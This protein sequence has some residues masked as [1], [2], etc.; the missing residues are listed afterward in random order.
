[1]RHPIARRSGFTLIELLVVI[2]VISLLSAITFG[3][4]RA[5]NSSRNKSKSRGDIQAIAMA[6]QSFRKVYGDFPCRSA[7]G[8]DDDRF[9]RDL[10]DQLIGRRVL[11]IVT[12]GTLPTLLNFDDSSLPGDPTKRQ[13]RS[14][15]TF[16]EIS[17]NDDT[18]I[19]DPNDWRGGSTA[20]C[21]EFVDA[22]GNPYDYRYRVL[23]VAKF[24]E[25]KSP[26]F[27]F[28]CA[29]ANYVEAPTE[30]D[31]LS[32]GEYWDP[33]ASGGT[34]MLRS[35]IV[36]GTYFDESGSNAGPFRADNLVNWSN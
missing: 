19:G 32:L 23:T 26:N 33:A 15:L 24:P 31:I 11:R 4:F 35:G 12:P 7:I 6:C 27:L 20:A 10:L 29:S 1:M 5:A 14:F 22:W 36:P 30:G 25:W 28:V 18:K 17:T 21:R 13:M 3:L 8:A 9:R 16:Q 2:A 34:T